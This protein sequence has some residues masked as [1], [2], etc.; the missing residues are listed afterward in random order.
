MRGRPL[1]TGATLQDA[2]AWLRSCG[3]IDGAVQAGE[4]VPDFALVNADDISVD[5]GTLLDRGPVVVTFVLGSDSPICRASL[6]TLQN[7]LPAID[8]RH[9]TLVAISPEPP[10]RSRAVA[11]EDGL[12]FDMLAD[13][14]H[15]LGRLFGLTYRPPE[16]VAAW[17]DLLG[18]AASPE[19]MP[20]DLILPATYI[21]DSDGVAAYAFL[22]PDPR[23]RADPRQV[24]EGLSRMPRGSA[25]GFS[26]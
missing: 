2:T 12:R 1:A 25:V 18:F 13:D 3:V 15:Q 11:A 24:V 20:A 5:L 14:D 6:R 23:Q 8:A 26:G 19:P 4:M 7:A 17:L 22:E 16:P 10:D 9:G 21:V